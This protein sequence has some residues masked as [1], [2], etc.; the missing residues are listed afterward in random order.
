MIDQRT[1]PYAALILRLALGLMFVAHGA[2]KLFVFTPAGTVGYFA[3]L[4]L[5]AIFAYLTIA[6]ELGGGVLL[7][8]GVATRP[9]AL[10]LIPLLIGAGVLGHGGNGWVFSNQGGGWEYPAFL[11]V[12]AVVQVLLGDGAAALKPVGYKKG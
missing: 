7:L 4:G 5:P 2:L 1:A 8:L 9:V 12:A 3:S 11:V 6:A 10:A